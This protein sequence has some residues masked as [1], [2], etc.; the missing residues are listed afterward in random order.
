MN[1]RKRL[2][3]LENANDNVH[4]FDQLSDEDL[5]RKLYAI[6]TENLYSSDP[7]FAEMCKVEKVKLE[8]EVTKH[9]EFELR[10]DVAAAIIANRAKGIP[11]SDYY[12]NWVALATEWRLPCVL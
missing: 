5:N 4:P 6:C 9:V 1:L 2:E 7:E 3:K 10:P 11:K 8:T 12:T